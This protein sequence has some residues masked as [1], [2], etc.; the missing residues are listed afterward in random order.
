MEQMEFEKL[1]LKDILE[2]YEEY[3][4]DTKLELKNIYKL[5]NQDE[6]R[7]REHNLKNR[8]YSLEVNVNKPYF[9]RIDF[10]NE[11]GV[12]DICYIG[13][14]GVSNYDNEIVVVDWRAPISSLYYD[15]IIG[16][17]SYKVN[18]DSINGNL[19][20]KRQYNIENKQLIG[21]FDVDTVSN[22]DLLKPYL[23]INADARTKNIVATIQKEQNDIIRSDFSKNLIIQGVAGSG[24]TTVA[25]HRIA[26]LAYNYRNLINNEQYMV[27]GPNKFFV[28][29]ISDMLPE[30][31]VND[32][33]QYDLVE[34]TETF[35]NQKLNL[36]DESEIIKKYL[37]GYKNDLPK[38]KTD[39][40]YKNIID[41]YFKDYFTNNINYKPIT[42]YDFIVIDSTTIKQYWEEV[43][44]RDYEDLKSAINRLISLLSKYCENNKETIL[45]K[46]NK[47]IELKME[48]G[49][50]LLECR[51][52]RTNMIDK[53]QSN[54][55]SIIK[56]H[57][58]P[59]LKTSTAI[60]DDIKNNMNKY[61]SNKI[62]LQ[63]MNNNLKYED[64]P[65]LI[66][67]EYKI[68][69]YKDFDKYRHIVIDEAQDYNTFSFIALQKIFPKASFSIYGDIAQSIYS[70]RSLDNWE[71]I[72]NNFFKT[73]DIKYLNKSY[74]TTI[75]IMSEA[76]KIN[77][78]LNLPEASAVI[79]HG[80]EVTYKKV[81]E[82]EEFIP[83]I[84]ELI[85]DGKKSIA[86]ISKD[87]E[88]SN[89]LYLNLKNNINLTNISDKSVEYIN[90]ICTISCHLCKG[91]E[92]DAVI[93]NNINDF[94]IN[95]ILEMKLLYVAMTRALHSLVM[96]YTKKIP[97]L[98]EKNTINDN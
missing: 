34:L 27:I 65:A 19:K 66:Y 22:D 97:S 6:A 70:Y 28:N 14:V 52:M 93:V 38:I 44:K 74:R 83:L 25:L 75:E 64:L 86:I 24:K 87:T 37:H 59:M 53:F 98:L 31:N 42:I 63:N 39:L 90:G 73:V 32:V 51:K 11:N 26:Y 57:F 13:K 92:F 88:I 89:T 36:Q 35:I 15:S 80:N 45:S 17:T 69:G 2:K 21:F 68:N 67:I 79:R 54:I 12:E 82:A 23:S 16:K 20:L 58:K 10:D 30:L 3:I 77:K 46:I 71:S 43:L 1:K 18:G 9:A 29:Y 40:E 56:S 72:K 4:D 62:I 95:N 5:Y 60:Y 50:D 48:D 7:E 91:L 81:L 76:N 96:T 94:D 33:A 55:N 85:A 78:Y 41:T 61:T 47:H 49:A 8:L 84:N